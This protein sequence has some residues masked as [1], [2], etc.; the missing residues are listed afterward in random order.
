MLHL[1]PL[2][3]PAKEDFTRIRKQSDL[4]HFEGILST[5]QAQALCCK[6]YFTVAGTHISNSSGVGMWHTAQ[7][8]SEARKE[9]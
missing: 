7:T 3:L 5:Y 6:Q 8:Q 9:T 1:Q 2:P 4:P